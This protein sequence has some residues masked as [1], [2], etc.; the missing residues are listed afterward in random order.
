VDRSLFQLVADQASARPDAIAVEEGEER[1]TYAELIAAA[2]AVAAGLLAAG[3]G[4]EDVV[5]VELCR[6]RRAVCAYLGIVRAGAGYMP[7]NPSHPRQRRQK[8]AE[9]A[10]A[11]AVIG[12]GSDNTLDVDQL[13]AAPAARP[14]PEAAGGDGLACVLF[15][16]GSTGTPKAVEITH[17][18][19]VN[20]LRRPSDLLPGPED[21]VLHKAVL[22]FDGS[23]LEIW[24]ALLNGARLV[25]SPGE[26][27]PAAIGRLIVR[28][29]VTMAVFPPGLLDEMA[30]FTLPS[31]A[32]LR[33]LAA[34]GD[35]LPPALV[36]ELRS[37]LPNTRLVNI[38]GPTETTIFATSYEVNGDE[39]GT[40]PI[41]RAAPGYCLHVLDEDGE[42]VPEGEPG[43][44]WIGGA[45]VARGY[46]DDPERTAERFH[47]DPFDG[48]RMY[49]S[50][51]LVRFRG[52]GQ[53]LFLGRVD[54]QVKIAGHRVEPGEI[55]RAL[56]AQP[57]VRAAAVAVRED[58][59]GHNRVIGYAVPRDGEELEAEELRTRLEDELPKF[60]VPAA[61]VPLETLPLTERGKVDR[62]ALPAP[63]RAAERETR[64]PRLEP[65]AAAM[66]DLLQLESVGPREDFFALG[67][68][69]LLALRLTGL[70]RDRLGADL[71]IRDV[72]EA[73]TAA[74]LAERIEHGGSRSSGLPPLTRGSSQ[75]IA[76]LSGAQRRAWLFCRMHPESIAYQFAAIFR[77]EGDLDV[78]TLRASLGDL[79]RRH[80]ILRTSFEERDGEPV[81]AIRPPFEAPLAEAD[82]RGESSAAWARLARAKVREQIALEPAPL[83]RWTLARLG[84]QSWRLIQVEHHLVHDGWSFSLLSGELA[85][86]YSARVEGRPADLPEPAA[87]FQDYTRWEREVRASEAVRRQIEH[88]AERLDP[89]PP[90][91]QL[92]GSRPRPPRESF[93]G[94]LV[95]RR[96][97]PELV[98]AMRSLAGEC[99]AT[100]FM[101]SLA[102]FL[103]QLQRY[104]GQDRQQ[105][106]TGIAN[107]R[108][109]LAERLIGMTVNTVALRCDLGDDPTVRELVARVRAAAIDAYANADAPFDAVVDAIGPP[110]DPGRS[111]LIQAL[112]SFHDAPRPP[113]GWSGLEVKVAEGIPNGTAK[114]DLNVIGNAREDGSLSFSWEHSDLIDDAMADRLAGHHQ[115]LLEQLAADPD[116][117]LSELDLLSDEDRAEL[118][119]WSIS[120]GR[121][122]RQATVVSLLEARAERDPD[123][124]AV[125]DGDE[126]IGYGELMGRARALAGALQQ[127]GIGRGDRVGI[128]VERSLGSVVAHCGVLLAGAAYVPLDPLHPAARI[129]RALEDAGAALCIVAE[130]PAFPL[131]LG[132]AALSLSEAE[133]GDPAAAVGVEPDDLAY[134]MYTSGS[135][136]EPKGVEITHRNV[137]R[138][139]ADPCFADL[140]PGRTMLHAASP[141]FDAATLELWGP[142]ASG[143][144]VACLRERP[145]P[146]TVAEAIERQGVDVLWLTAGLFHELVD[147]RPGC[148]AG[149]TH[150]LAGG[151]VLS[152]DHVRRAL[153]ALPPRGRLTNGYG[154]TEATTF[155][156]THE[157][158]PGDRVEGPVPIGRPIQGT[159]CRVLDRTCR[160]VPVGVIGE[161][162][163]GGDGVARGYRNDA[164]LTAARFRAD[165]RSPGGRIYLTG[166]LVRRRPDGTLEFA[167]R[168]DR[169]VKI[170]GQRIEPAEVESVLR[171]HPGVA[172]TAVVPFERAPGDLALAAYVVA[173]NRDAAPESA[174]LRAHTAARLPSAM[175]PSAWIP[176]PELPL[177]VNGKLDLG[178]LPDPGSEHLVRQGG[179][180]EPRGK[181]ERRV[182]DAF[183]R[184]LEVEPVGVEDDFFALGGHSLLAVALFEELERVAGRRLPLALIFEASTPRA[185]AAALEAPVRQDAWANLV[186]LKP[187]GTRPPLFAVAAGD[188]NIVGFG[189]LA[190]NMPA[191]QPFYALQPSGL[192]GRRPLDTGIE[193]MAERYLRALRSVQPRG[194]YLLAGRCNGATVAF[195]MA[196]RL[197]AEGEEVPLLLALDSS[198]PGPKPAEL[199][200]GLPYDELM[201]AAAVRAR[202][203]GERVPD[204]G[205]GARLLAWLREPV[206][207]GVSRYMYEFWR[208]RDDLREGWPDPLGADAAPFAAFT[209]SHALGEL[210]PQL[211]LPAVSRRC[212]TADGTAWDWAMAAAWE[213]RQFSPS[214][215]LSPAGWREFRAHLLEPV[216]D[217]LNNYLLGALQRPDLREWLGDPPDAAA[218][219][220]WAWE[221][222][223]E[224]SLDHRLLPSPPLPLSRRRRLKLALRPTRELGFGLRSRTSVRG[225]ELAEQARRRLLDKAEWR[226]GRPLPGAGQRTILRALEAARKAR[227]SYRADPWPGTVVLI[228]SDEFEDKHT[229]LGWEMRAQGGVERHRLPHGHV[230]MLREPGA[231][232]LARCLS[233]R[234]EEA[235]AE[236]P[237]A[238]TSL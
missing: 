169:Q 8:L 176:L 163:I 194:P 9:L 54:D 190:R 154:P 18:G 140:G 137:V 185:L 16:S 229:Y 7:L 44:L 108:E 203:A 206:G 85:E 40:V 147:R 29:G 236:S 37:A 21:V 24:S 58:V 66:A 63:E 171:A 189:P 120:A 138:L 143:G 93:A 223:P 14:A 103:V 78:P 74:G 86:L 15:T 153:A 50:G 237:S 122:D 231:A 205:S 125:V 128:L 126:Q 1:L 94:G 220:G 68:T 95:R 110:R 233:D 27:D 65:I 167:G 204:P 31:L 193:E 91:L 149:V 141:A 72:F 109:P 113:G 59:P 207:P 76:P 196:Q 114:A 157:L 26:P 100:L 92:P 47:P 217:G 107:R 159:S 41:G 181:L 182:V 119:R 67:G 3:S 123:A 183:E 212:R 178:S 129:V 225:R 180:A 155:A 127:H 175:V 211:L 75:P 71:G 222:G 132:T 184:V 11:R 112:F 52:D 224:E 164:E 124:V 5:G 12:D 51:D 6:G 49:R 38:Y 139:V 173:G 45:G 46:R 60:M 202:L 161:M 98:E 208:S 135:T 179:G 2:E 22:D 145:S 186:A 187:S 116:T 4:P 43:E 55:E 33:V 77:I 88:W 96:V 23:L 174:E 227:D 83:V 213:R 166:D 69:S 28:H 121:H 219:L 17:G 117:R 234:V 80:E 192:D 216:A 61:I 25:V 226:L 235:L 105:I 115:R 214:D 62:N 150:L 64:D 162:A 82:L 111:P 53:L 218:L 118:D 200:P 81:Q 20:Q 228:V 130:E 191:D 13:L 136:G 144:T 238:W 210:A 70:L 177:T 152:P 197:R 79:I 99:E 156:T 172:D 102:A 10:G 42:L 101:V 90:L 133:A 36:A 168:A 48:G 151:D 158:R 199:V 148:L 131:P 232:D 230:E 35:V 19:L 195:E 160:E 73:R 215:P 89:D 106:G 165:P 87:Q 97:P 32:G 104:S 34:G 201:E 142:L 30:R 188:G 134:V 56:A 146:D 39:E 84:E 198:P 221:H 209:W 170:R 57:G